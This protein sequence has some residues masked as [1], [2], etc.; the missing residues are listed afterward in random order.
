MTEFVF[1]IL[2]SVGFRHPIHPALTHL[3]MGLVMGA[4]FFRLTAL[5]TPMKYLAK[6]A[7]H[8]VVGA[9]IFVVP[10]AI[11]G[12]MDWQHRYDGEWEFLIGLKI[13]LA[14]V[15]TIILAVI[16]KVDDPENPQIDWKSFLYILTV[17]TAVGLGFSGGELIFG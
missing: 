13:V 2:N 8:C 10:T 17:M 14:I 15:I 9:L 11:L 12:Y 5:F 3:P 6:T 4:F 7:Y 1:S 16:V